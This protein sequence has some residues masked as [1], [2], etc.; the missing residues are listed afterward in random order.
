MFCDLGTPGGSAEFA[1]YDELKSRLEEKGIPAEGIRFIHDAGNDKAKKERLFKECRDGKVSVLVGSTEKCGTGMNIQHRLAALHHLDVPWRP[2]DLEQREGRIL[3]QGNQ[4]KQVHV[5]KYLAEGSFDVYSW[6]TVER[7]ALFIES[8]MSAR[9]GGGPRSY[10]EDDDQASM[11]AAKMKAIAANNQTMIAH[12]EATD[13][14]NKLERRKETHMKDQTRLENIRLSSAAQKARLEYLID[15]AERMTPEP[16]GSHADWTTHDWEFAFAPE[17]KRI[18]SE[19]TDQAIER[20]EQLLARPRGDGRFDDSRT[21]YENIVGYHKMIAGILDGDETI[22]RFGSY[23]SPRGRNISGEDLLSN[24]MNG[25]VEDIEN[26]HSAD[27]WNKKI[28]FYHQ[29]STAGQ[30]LTYGT[31][32]GSWGGVP[33]WVWPY[34]GG[35]EDVTGQITCAYVG[36]GAGGVRFESWPRYKKQPTTALTRMLTNLPKTL[37]NR[38]KRLS[39]VEQDLRSVKRRSGRDFPD[40]EELTRARIKER[41]LAAQLAAEQEKDKQE[42]DSAEPSAP[43][44]G[45]PPAR[46]QTAAGEAPVATNP[47]NIIQVPEPEARQVSSVEAADDPARVAFQ[48]G[49]RATQDRHQ[50]PGRRLEND[51]DYRAGWIAGHVNRAR[52]GR[53]K[54]SALPRVNE[55]LERSESAGL[56]AEE[57]DRLFDVWNS[58]MDVKAGIEPGTPESRTP[59]R[60]PGLVVGDMPSSPAGREAEPTVDGAERRRESRD[61]D[62]VNVRVIRSQPPA[63]ED[64]G[65]EQASPAPPDQDEA[66]DA[67]EERR[68]ELEEALKSDFPGVPIRVVDAG[69]PPS[70]PVSD[71]KRRPSRGD[72]GW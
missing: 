7:K 24:L 55:L 60:H 16:G 33:L 65:A 17:W 35:P 69:L 2:A 21:H 72:I 46:E 11:T 3:R 58:L 44:A 26:R 47:E 28:P 20:N 18:L 42:L 66:V 63:G 38:R 56:S 37:D 50:P 43:E 71:E 45:N 10:E 8:L 32:V 54:V 53:G 13:R 12:L 14:L 40:E 5:F 15:Q 57:I 34:R 70:G 51:P 62:R 48:A 36:F 68:R 64:S 39:K 27:G 30:P 59:K 67:A 19:K 29:L 4:H 25:V 22:R 23:T 31:E 9:S 1:V 6:Q 49:W 41:T 52:E 61:K